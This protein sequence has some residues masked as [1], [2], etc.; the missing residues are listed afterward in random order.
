MTPIEQLWHDNPLFT[1]CLVLLIVQWLYIVWLRL[2]LH[3]V[4][5]KLIKAQSKQTPNSLSLSSIDRIIE[6]G[7]EKLRN[8]ISWI[9]ISWKRVHYSIHESLLR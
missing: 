6:K 5:R 8:T 2:R 4:Q 3:H 1:L 9:S 7:L